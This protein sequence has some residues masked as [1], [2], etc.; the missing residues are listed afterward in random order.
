MKRVVTLMIGVAMTA[1]AFS[2]LSIGV[3]ATGNLSDANIEAADFVSSTKKARALP[4]AGVV[5]DI[6]VSPKVTVRTGV[7]FLQSGITLKASTPGIPGEIDEIAIKGKLN[8][9]YLQVPL[10]VLYTSNGPVK[11][12]VGGG[13]YFSYAVSGKSTQE[14]TIKFSDGSTETEK[15]ETDPFEKDDEGESYWKR[16]DFGIGAIAGVKLP[17][18]LFAN[19]GYQYSFANLSKADD[20]KYNNRGLQLTIG[21]YLWRK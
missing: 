14:T 18:G 21:Y 9:N 16:T 8:M 5:A 12:Y 4:G 15:E 20:E 1:T 19:V 13:P 10:N 6:A 17:G 3:Q 7:N 2:Q 11:F